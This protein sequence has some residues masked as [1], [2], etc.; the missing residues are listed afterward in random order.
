MVIT[1]GYAPRVRDG[2]TS[3]LA[4]GQWS[5]RGSRQ[6]GG[7]PC[8]GLLGPVELMYVIVSATENDMLLRGQDE[9][10]GMAGGTPAGSGA[11]QGG[12]GKGVPDRLQADPGERHA[13]Q[14]RSAPTGSRGEPGGP[15]GP[16]RTQELEND[17]ALQR[18][19]EPS[20]PA[21]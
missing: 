7:L 11:V 15:A 16:A 2:I 9:Q 21:L 19:L 6:I 17:D 12:S 14:L 1:E 18:G 20:T 10:Q 3:G 4:G 13:P 5:V 8:V